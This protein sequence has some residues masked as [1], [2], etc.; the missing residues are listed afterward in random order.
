VKIQTWNMRKIIIIILGEKMKNQIINKEKL[1]DCTYLFD[2]YNELIVNK[3]KPGQF[4]ILRVHE[5]GERIPLTIN[6]INFV[7]NTIR[8]IFVVVGKT[9]HDL[10]L[11]ET[12][13]VILDFVGPLGNHTEVEGYENKNVCIIGGGIGCAISYPVAKG[14]KDHQANIYTI[15]GFRN[16]ELVILEEEFKKMSNNHITCT[17]DGSYGQLGYVTEALNEIIKR[18]E[19]SLIYAVG[20]LIM[21]KNVVKIAEK[22]SIPT[23]VSLNPIMIDG[24]GMCGGCRVEVGNKILFAC[25]DGPDFPGHLVNFDAAIARNKMYQKEERKSSCNLFK[26]VK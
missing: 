2:V 6:A 20:P 7:E 10:S 19:F 8:I 9:T 26:D 18:Y 15:S 23:I 4:I 3:A 12:G 21:M 13:D 16:K 17:D 1:N 14:F 24:T 22:N 11:L 5:K 25:V